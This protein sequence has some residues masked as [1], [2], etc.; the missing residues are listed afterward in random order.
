MMDRCQPYWVRRFVR[1]QRHANTDRKALFLCVGGFDED[2]FFKCARMVVKTWCLC[3]DVELS[4]ELFYKG[5][6]RRGDIAKHP[7]ALTE[8]LAAGRTLVS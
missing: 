3:L 2:R 1:N 5:I 8:A 4:A 6:D 7:T